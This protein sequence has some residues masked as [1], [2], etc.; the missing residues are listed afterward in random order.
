M[1]CPRWVNSSHSSS[2]ILTLAMQNIKE[3]IEGHAV[4][5]YS[6]VFNIV[7]PDVDLE[8]ANSLWGEQLKEKDKK[9]KRKSDEQ[10]NSR[11]GDDAEEEDEDD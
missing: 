5:W 8:R 4:G 1:N 7:F 10:K 2:L 11:D 9:G 6:E 3:N